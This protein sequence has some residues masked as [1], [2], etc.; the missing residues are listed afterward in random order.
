MVID[1]SALGAIILEEPDASMYASAILNDAVRLISSA[2]L[3]EISLVLI[4]RREPNATAALDALISRLRVVV[5]AVDRDQAMLAREAFRRYGKGIH[6]AG[7][8]FGDCF[9]YAL[10]KQTRETLLFKGNDFAQT[11]IPR[12]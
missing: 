1:S 6:P 7:L 10:A 8:N 3:V 2:T 12:A 9:S 4:R 11:D 5:V